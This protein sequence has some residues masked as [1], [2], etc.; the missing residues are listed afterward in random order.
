MSDELLKYYK[1]ERKYLQ[2]FLA[3]ELVPKHPKI[4]ARLGIGDQ[5]IEDPSLEQLVEA[6]SLMNA[7]LRHKIEDDFPE[8]SH[9]LL[10]ALHPH[11]QAPIPSMSIAQFQ[12]NFQELTHPLR[13]PKN[14]EILSQKIKD[15]PSVPFKT[16][17]DTTVWPIEITNA[18]FDGRPSELPKN[19]VSQNIK[20]IL[21]ISLSCP[22][23]VSFQDLQPDNLRFFI[24]APSAPYAYRVYQWLICHTLQ[25]QVSSPNAPEKSAFCQLV[26]VGFDMQEGLLPYPPQTML[27]Q[28]WL[29]EFCNLPE[30]FL[31]FEVQG[32]AE[33][34]ARAD[35]AQNCI[36]TF[37]F[38]EPNILL[39]QHLK[40]D[41]F[42]LGCTPIINLFEQTLEE[43]KISSEKTEYQLNPTTEGNQK[44]TEVYAILDVKETHPKTQATL[45]YAQVY[46]IRNS[47]ELAEPAGYW[48]QTRKAAWQ[49]KHYLPEG[50][51]VFL[52]FMDKAG[53]PFQEKQAF[54]QVNALCLYRQIRTPKDSP[55]YFIP[56]E[57]NTMI[58]SIHTLTPV[59]PCRWPSTEK[60]AVW[61]LLSHL[62]PNALCFSGEE[63]GAE[64]MREMLRLYDLTGSKKTSFIDGILSISEKLETRPKPRVRGKPLGNPLW[65]G[66]EI[67]LT[68]DP[69]F[70]HSTSLFLFGC[71]L[72]NWLA[73]YVP[74]STF[75]QLNIVNNTSELLYAFPMRK[76]QGASL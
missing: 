34:I 69:E 28:R 17:Y 33:A 75:T 27:N 19:T 76:G 22:L 37:C 63:K 66:V 65:K 55:L 58:T 31:F 7:R 70:F 25:V 46:G 61:H 56:R 59:T 73:R 53:E 2:Q 44:N 21:S 18:S 14:Y 48:H 54:I 67:T 24:S 5:T 20:S 8:I 57:E 51:E 35:I 16:C 60:Y 64:S 4:A 1:E 50:T 11:Y 47:S 72:E 10:T 30:K 49:G 52:S 39:E 71:L 68:V 38:D 41:W 12:P 74:P 42:A 3:T 45:E 9:T 62:N 29:T 15:N 36:L 43:I 26:P 6:Y 40:T 32:L 13:I 23:K